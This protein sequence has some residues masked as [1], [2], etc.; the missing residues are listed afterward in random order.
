MTLY[1]NIGHQFPDLTAE[2]ISLN[3]FKLMLF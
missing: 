1:G 2:H 3:N